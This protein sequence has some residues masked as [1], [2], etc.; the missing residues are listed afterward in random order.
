MDPVTAGILGLGVGAVVV[1]LDVWLN[2]WRLTAKDKRIETLLA[3][4]QTERDL[5]RVERSE[6]NARIQGFIVEPAKPTLDLAQVDGRLVPASQA[7]GEQRSWSEADLVKLH[8][9]ENSDGGYI[10]SRSGA[11]FESIEAAIHWRESLKGAG[12]RD[13]VRPDTAEIRGFEAA[14]EEARRRDVPK[15]DLESKEV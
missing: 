6:M 4:W 8:L 14:L 13:D 2:E 3:N 10:D 5:W 1:Y 12:M 7:A 15:T 9:R 11:L